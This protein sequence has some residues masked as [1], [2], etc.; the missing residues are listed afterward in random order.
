MNQPTFTA[1]LLKSEHLNREELLASLSQNHN[2]AVS[3]RRPATSFT[4]NTRTQQG[5][6]TA[7]ADG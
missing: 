1:Q 3:D 5:L 6:S 2:T 7:D 4:F